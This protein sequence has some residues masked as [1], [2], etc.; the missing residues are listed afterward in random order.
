[1]SQHS[2]ATLEDAIAVAWE[3]AQEALKLL[4]PPAFSHATTQ[5]AAPPAPQGE[6]LSAMIL[7]KHEKPQSDPSAVPVDAIRQLSKDVRA[8]R[9]EVTQPGKNY[10]YITR[11]HALHADFSKHKND[12]PGELS[13]DCGREKYHCSPFMPPDC[14]T[15][16]LQLTI[17][18]PPGHTVVIIIT[19]T[20]LVILTGT[21]HPLPLLLHIIDTTTIL[22]AAR[23]ALGAT[24]QTGVTLLTA[25]IHQADSLQT[26]LLLSL[27]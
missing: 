5:F 18:D 21:T 10:S 16:F 6:P 25:Y 7:T 11:H 14:D 4:P 27:I 12:S 17:R 13:G 15:T 26:C 9:V 23:I 19:D 24:A 1:M 8:L 22:P 3:R 20:L 2:T